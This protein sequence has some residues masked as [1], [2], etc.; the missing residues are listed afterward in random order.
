[1]PRFTCA[2]PDI[3]QASVVNVKITVD[4]ASAVPGSAEALN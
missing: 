3:A 1:M 2:G 4:C